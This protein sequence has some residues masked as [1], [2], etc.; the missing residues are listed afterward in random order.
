MRLSGCAVSAFDGNGRAP[1]SICGLYK[2]NETAFLRS[3]GGFW[4]RF[5]N[6][7]AASYD[8]DVQ[9][10]PQ[11]DRRIF[12]RHH[13]QP[14][15]IDGDCEALS[16]FKEVC[17]IALYTDGAYLCNAFPQRR[18][19]GWRGRLSGKAAR[20]SV[21]VSCERKAPAKR[22]DFCE[23][24]RKMERDSGGSLLG[25]RAEICFMRPLHAISAWLEC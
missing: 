7:E 14:H 4:E 5:Q 8:A 13:Q 2:A 6:M 22:N 25:F 24:S 21:V 3:C 18:I 19:I 12:W 9:K 15:G 20:R 1:G 10:H 23:K 16:L 17:I 11:G